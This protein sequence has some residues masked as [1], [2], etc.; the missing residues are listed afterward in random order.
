MKFRSSILI[1]LIVLISGCK[2]GPNY[3]VPETCMPETFS[4]DR[5]QEV[6]LICDESLVEWWKV[7]NDP[8]LNQLLEEA[9][10][11]SFDYLV[12]L[13]KVKQARSQ[14]W[15]QFTKILPEL[16]SSA[17]AM[18]LRS[19]ELIGLSPSGPG[20]GSAL[21]NLY[22]IGLDAIWEIDLF[23]KLRRSADASYDL[24]Q[25][26]AED[27]RG[28]KITILSE[29]AV[30]Y[31]NIC[32]L[33]KNIDLQQ[34]LLFLDGQILSLSQSR[35][36]AGLTNEQEIQG[37]IASQQSDQAALFTLET[38]LRQNI[39]SLAILVG[40]TPE[41][42]L[43]DFQIHRP[44]PKATG[45][46]TSA[47]IPGDL[48]RRR[49]DI[50]SA[51][52]NLASATEQ[53]GV[54]V[55]DLYPSISLVGFNGDLSNGPGGAF[56]GYTA[57]TIK[58]LFHTISQTWGIGTLITWPV[59]DFG[60]RKANLQVQY[61]LAEQAYLNYQKTVIT[62]LQ[63]TESA[64]VAYYNEIDRYAALNKQIQANQKYFNY[65][66]SLYKEGLS[67]FTQVY[68]AKQNLVNSVNNSVSS[69]LAIATDLIHLYKALGGDW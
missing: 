53:I 44:I 60:K 11:G 50:A 27:A 61:S 7:F 66:E 8:F 58:S 56:F 2:V 30:T 32:S 68:Q 35:F 9:T 64:L 33:Q 3:E 31:M 49:P 57:N 48:L 54:A 19:E 13:E 46:I 69:E 20:T 39:Y 14:Y 51:E 15:I 23:G 25:A 21:Q 6:L 47:G 18:R 67:N 36:Q 43:A 4:E 24:W 26:S 42:L 16:D 41:C 29:V 22:E 37:F 10:A 55:A 65:T 59:F 45:A 12:A 1:F 5:G 34:Q 63:E 28:V 17:L 62:A 52:R 40:R 38:S